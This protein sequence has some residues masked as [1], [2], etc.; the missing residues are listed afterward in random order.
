MKYKGLQSYTEADA[1][2]FKGR[3]IETKELL[4]LLHTNDIVVCYAASGEGKSSLINAGL[5]PLLRKELILPIFITFSETDFSNE[6]IDFNSFVLGKI[7]EA[8]H[9]VNKG[10]LDENSQLRF[11]SDEILEEK[12]GKELYDELNKN[13]WWQLRMGYLCNH[14]QTFIPLLI[15]DQFEE[16]FCNTRSDLWINEFFQWFGDFC[17]GRLPMEL[18]DSIRNK[19]EDSF[20]YL[21][22]TPQSSV[23]VLFSLRSDYVGD[24]DYWCNQRYKIPVLKDTRYLLKPLTKVGAEEVLDLSDFNRDVKNNIITFVCKDNDQ[25][26]VSALILSVLC[27]ILSA[28]NKINIKNDLSDLSLLVEE[29]YNDK[30]SILDID[31][32]HEL[33]CSLIG[34]KNNRLRIPFNADRFKNLKIND[35]RFVDTK[36]NPVNLE[37][38]RI[39]RVNNSYYIELV[40]DCL[41]SVVTKKKAQY[42]EDLTYQKEQAI[43]QKKNVV[44]LVWLLGHL[45]FFLYSLFYF[46]E[47]L[48]SVIDPNKDVLSDIDYIWFVLTLYIPVIIALYTSSSFLIQN[49]KKL[50]VLLYSF[51]EI[52]LLINI[53]DFNTNIFFITGKLGNEVFYYLLCCSIVVGGLLLYTFIDVINK[54][55]KIRNISEN[56]LP[57]N[58]LYKRN[59]YWRGYIFLIS[60]VSVV[61]FINIDQFSGLSWLLLA[62]PFLFYNIPSALNSSKYKKLLILL[63]LLLILCDIPIPIKG[64]PS[65]INKI[66]G[67]FILILC[68]FFSFVSIIYEYKDKRKRLILVL[69]NLL[70][71]VITYTYCLGFIPFANEINPLNVVL[72]RTRSHTYN[73]FMIKSNENGTYRYGFYNATGDTIISSVFEDCVTAEKFGYWLAFKINEKAILSSKDN[74][75][76]QLGMSIRNDTLYLQPY[77]CGLSI[78]ADKNS[79]A[80][81][82]SFKEVNNKSIRTK[83]DLKLQQEYFFSKGYNELL[84]SMF[85]KLSNGEKFSSNSLPSIKCLCEITQCLLDSVSNNMRVPENE[86]QKKNMFDEDELI[87]DYYKYHTQLLVFSVLLD[88]F[89]QDNISEDLIYYIAFYQHFLINEI[90]KTPM[91]IFNYAI[92]SYFTGF[93][94]STVDSIKFD[95]DKVR[96]LLKNNISL[97]QYYRDCWLVLTNYAFSRFVTMLENNEADYVKNILPTYDNFLKSEDDNKWILLESYLTKKD[98]WSLFVETENSYILNYVDYNI[99]TSIAVVE[100]MGSFYNSQTRLIPYK[101]LV[102][103]RFYNTEYDEVDSMSEN[104]EK[105]DTILN[106]SFYKKLDSIMDSVG[107]LLQNNQKYEELIEKLYL[108]KKS[109]S[110]SQQFH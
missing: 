52:L 71:I 12:L 30:I 70:I 25:P 97:K 17:S 66:P 65:L 98:D 14:Y 8:V 88:C 10:I 68:I 90:N 107:I 21:K 7:F 110:T 85:L 41:C 106:N 19:F 58:N 92:S 24:L 1:T 104:L 36:N 28:K 74:S 62:L 46:Y 27:T 82:S 38:L 67:M 16:I 59:I 15:F 43:R 72:N 51:S 48:F 5:C 33:E 87:A 73:G 91:K 89:N 4:N 77:F 105:I 47:P 81:E 53:F 100:S 49:I 94:K 80:L 86:R 76:N 61:F 75:F 103:K 56:V 20:N 32:I 101:L 29:F 9:D 109:K 45:L 102:L 93:N 83:S 6:K 13:A 2:N 11:V 78:A 54:K 57:K 44:T 3:S 79:S 35:G 108:L 26:Y 18:G 96:C 40:H 50:D 95:N 60:L 63:W 69:F 64:W 42:I 23:K 55:C 84:N 22:L 39:S 34:E 31:D 99:K 37:I